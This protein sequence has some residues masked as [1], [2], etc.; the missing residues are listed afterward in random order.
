MI[1]GAH[2]SLTDQT[3]P[4]TPIPLA[5]VPVPPTNLIRGFYQAAILES[6]TDA[7]WPSRAIDIPE[8]ERGARFVPSSEKLD[9]NKDGFLDLDEL[10]VF[11]DW[12]NYHH[13]PGT[14][15]SES[16]TKQ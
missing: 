7:I 8:S 14:P 1:S 6:L 10:E 5:P 11:S 15:L 3:V 2:T 13:Q 9:R 12:L 16:E 4:G